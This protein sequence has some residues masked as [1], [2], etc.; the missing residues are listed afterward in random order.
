M[1]IYKKIATFIFKF[2]IGF[3]ISYIAYF[4]LLIYLFTLLMS[5]VLIASPFSQPLYYLVTLIF[6]IDPNVGINYS[7]ESTNPKEIYSYLGNI[8]FILSILVLIVNTIA[9]IFRKIFKIELSW[10]LLIIIP[11]I[12]SLVSCI[13][14]IFRITKSSFD[15]LYTNYLYGILSLSI[16]LGLTNIL[17][18]VERKLK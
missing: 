11:S 18:R 1:D 6:G 4:F 14:A 7:F 12:L 13:Y 10:K 2:T 16:Y 17:K 9:L 8:F 15:V 3:S 5:I